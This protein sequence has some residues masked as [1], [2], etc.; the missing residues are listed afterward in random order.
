MIFRKNKYSTLKVEKRSQDRIPE[1]FYVKDPLNGQMVYSKELERNLMV[2]QQSG[3]HFPLSAPDRIASLVDEGTFKEN[4]QGM[5]SADPLHFSGVSPYPDKLASHSKKTGLNDSV[6][7]GTAKMGGMPVSLAVM[8]FRFLGASMGSVAGEKITR[9]IEYG[10]E[11]GVPVI[12]VCASGGARMYEGILSLMQMA[13][14][15]AA[16][17]RLAKKGIPYFSILTNPTMA[18]V[19]AS[20]A[21]LGD[22]I[23]AEPGALIGFAGPRVIKETTQQ[24]LPE[25]FQTAEFL[26]DHGLIDQIVERK[27]LRNRLIYFLDT[28]TWAAKQA[29]ISP[30]KPKAK[31]ASK[32]ASAKTQRKAS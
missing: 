27:E 24:D 18:G 19:M 1:G 31:R 22:L 14:T 13:K 4:D 2:V 12:V 25:G 8:D 28:F 30:A 7:W 10:E 16:L 32:K 9:A 17:A 29:T 26:L 6:V 15:S 21:S 23:I 20:F 11:H 3:Y 5:K